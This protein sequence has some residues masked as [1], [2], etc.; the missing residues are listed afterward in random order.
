VS[1][2]IDTGSPINVIDEAVMQSLA[3]KPKLQA[4]NSRYF[5]F[6]SD[7]PIEVEGRFTMR[8]HFLSRSVV[9]EFIVVK[10]EQERLLSYKTARDLGIVQVNTEKD[11]VGTT[12]PGGDATRLNPV[13]TDLAGLDKEHSLEDLKRMFPE[14]FSGKLGCVKNFC[15][16]LDIDPTIRPTRQQQRPIP[17]HMRDVVEKELLE[18]IADDI[19]ERVD[20]NSGPTPWIANLVIV[21]KEQGVVLKDLK[22]EKHAPP[23][24]RLTCDTRQ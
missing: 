8:V 14:L 9:A 1:F 6:T 17:L 2:L 5:G 16:K 19:L 7:K 18:Q 4:C 3:I 11:G 21:P 23:E 10:G 12:W 24:I 20:E 15:V 13:E 22:P